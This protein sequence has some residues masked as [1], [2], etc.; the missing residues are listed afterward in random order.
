MYCMRCEE[1]IQVIQ[2][3]NQQEIISLLCLYIPAIYYLL[4]TNR[5]V[6]SR[7]VI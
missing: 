1:V 7:V 5:L 3:A 6:Q 4:N 2:L